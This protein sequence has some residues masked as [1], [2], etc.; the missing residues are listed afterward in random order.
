MSV[1]NKRSNLV[2]IIILV[3]ILMLVITVIGVFAKF[4]NNFKSGFKTFYVKFDGKFYTETNNNIHLDYGK[5]YNFECKYLLNE[6]DDKKADYN[7]KIVPNRSI[8]NNFIFSVDGEK[9][10]FLDVEDLT[11]AFDIYKVENGFILELPEDFTIS[12]CLKKVYAG[13]DVVITEGLFERDL[14]YTLVISSYNEKIVYYFNF[15]SLLEFIKL[16]KGVVK[17]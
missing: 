13:K 16:D 3:V 9:I 10:S 6:K 8:D 2:L 4:T 12:K 15:G 11:T 14:Y 7:V 1:K 17:F 5:K